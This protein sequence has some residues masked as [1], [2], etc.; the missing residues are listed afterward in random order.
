M[1]KTFILLIFIISCLGLNCRINEE[2]SYKQN[3]NSQNIEFCSVLANPENYLSK[4]IQTKVN[5]YGYHGFVAYSESCCE[6]GKIVSIDGIDYEMRQKM[7]EKEVNLAI[8]RTSAD[9]K[10]IVTISGK[11]EVNDLPPVQATEFKPKYKFT[12][13]EIKEYEPNSQS[14]A[15]SC[16]WN[17]ISIMVEK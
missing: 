2:L 9:F 4:R 8:P 11:L 1:K 6:V 17:Y 13:S 10:G 16:V 3:E 15:D 5:I 12:V 7:R 14:T